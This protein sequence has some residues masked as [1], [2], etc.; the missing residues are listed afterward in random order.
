MF[1]FETKSQHKV[2]AGLEFVAILLP[3]PPDD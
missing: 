2:Q 3:Q 1:S